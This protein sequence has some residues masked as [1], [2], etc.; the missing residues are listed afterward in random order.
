MHSNTLLLPFYRRKMP[1]FDTSLKNISLRRCVIIV[2]T[3]FLGPL[4]LILARTLYVCFLPLVCSQ[5]V[6][7][8]CPPKLST[9]IPHLPQTQPCL[10]A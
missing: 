2:A 4:N 7:R 8:P 5:V 9:V 1:V 6:Y 3:C 10:Q